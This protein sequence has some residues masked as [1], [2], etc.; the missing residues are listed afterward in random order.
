MGETNSCNILFGKTSSEEGR[1]IL[2]SREFRI[3]HTR[4]TLFALLAL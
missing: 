1:I 4:G 3:V 2:L